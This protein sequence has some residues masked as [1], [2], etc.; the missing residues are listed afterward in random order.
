MTKTCNETDIHPADLNRA[1]QFV[2][3]LD[4][5]D[6][7]PIYLADVLR[8]ALVSS[9]DKALLQETLKRAFLPVVTLEQF[10][11]M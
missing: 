1:L 8:S 5:F 3:W 6:E 10:E 2:H 11:S 9:A 4:S 7:A